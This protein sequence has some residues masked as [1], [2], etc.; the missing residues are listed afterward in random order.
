L[1]IL[2]LASAVLEGI[3]INA[4][5]PLLSSFTGGGASA[6]DPITHGIQNVFMYFGIPFTFRYLLGLILGLFL[7][8][9]LAMVVFSYIRGWTSADFMYAESRKLL[10]STLFASWP[11]LLQQKMGKLQNTLVRD[12]QRSST[13]LEIIGQIIQSF[14]GFI[15]YLLVAINISFTTTLYT[16]GAGALLVLFIR[17]FI[18]KSRVVGEQAVQVE[19]AYA[20]FLSEHIIGMK[21]VKAAGIE[22]AALAGGEQELGAQRALSLR[23]TLIRAMSGSFFQPFTLIFV[24]I[25]FLLTSGSPSFSIIS[26]IA[27]LYLIQKIFTYLESGMNALHSFGEL[28]PYAKNL[29]AFTELTH[30]HREQKTTGSKPLIFKEKIAFTNVSFAYNS[31]SHVLDSVSFTIPK[32]STFG[33]IGPSGSGKTTTA[34]LLLRLFHPTSGSITVDGQPV[35]EISISD[36][37]QYISYVSQDVF[38]LNASIAENIR[39]YA[40]NI[41]EADIETAARQANIYDFIMSLPQGFETT[42]GD[43]GVLLSGG[44]RQRV[45]LARA[46][47]RKPQLLIL[48][49]ATS[50]LDS[51]S[52]RLIQDS[53]ESLHGSVTVFVIAHRLST[54][55][56]VDTL[57]VLQGGRVA[58]I[59]SPEDLRSNPNSYFTKHHTSFT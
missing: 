51:E 9:A 1:A 52:E 45:V 35:E 33:V 42:V 57:L 10:E 36:W 47:V 28:T 22:E 18:R 25:L 4:V 37:R 23:L 29:N 26:F 14:G 11:F 17:P 32:G 8:R 24:V 3:G 39:F 58:E 41:T 6:T 21:S 30:E 27:T 49:E 59:G 20:H 19:K 55:E 31:D 54:I 7:I 34:D 40:S 43:R 44:Q 13:L 48:D 12:I 2:G 53:I 5:I 15:V 50:A 38:L 16:L 46:L 56:S